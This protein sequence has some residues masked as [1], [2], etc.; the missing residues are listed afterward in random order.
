VKFIKTLSDGFPIYSV[1]KHNDTVSSL[2]FRLPLLYTI[3]NMQVNLEGLKINGKYQL[4]KVLI[5]LM[6]WV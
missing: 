6:Y 4:W 1:L 5:I 2:I 3:S